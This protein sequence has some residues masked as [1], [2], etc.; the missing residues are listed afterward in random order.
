MYCRNASEIDRR[1][2]SSSDGRYLRE[3]RSQMEPRRV[4]G[5]R[6]QTPCTVHDNPDPAEQ[7]V[8]GR[9]PRRGQERGRTGRPALLY[10][11]RG[12][13]AFTFN[14]VEQSQHV[15]HVLPV[16]FRP[17]AL[18]GRTRSR[19]R[20]GTHQLGRCVTR[21]GEAALVDPLLACVEWAP[22]DREDGVAATP[23]SSRS[24]SAPRH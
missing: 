13:D 7:R 2:L 24:C 6:C 20:R 23:A 21:G 4:D 22:C 19:R 18:R 14:N 3:T 11:C 15:A 1:T 8:L 17:R 16:R 9:R 10:R 5:V 12:G